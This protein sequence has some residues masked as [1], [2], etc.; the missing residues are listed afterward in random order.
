MAAHYSKVFINIRDAR[1]HFRRVVYRKKSQFGGIEMR[2]WE[3]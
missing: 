2:S 3:I 1:C